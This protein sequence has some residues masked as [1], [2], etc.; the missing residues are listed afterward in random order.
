MR[1]S[2]TRRSVSGLSAEVMRC[3]CI[4]CVLSE[5]KAIKSCGKIPAAFRALTRRFI[6]ASASDAA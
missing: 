2:N 6:T 3:G 5:R 1:M 4:L